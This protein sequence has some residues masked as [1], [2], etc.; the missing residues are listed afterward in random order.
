[1]RLKVRCN[2]RC[3][4]CGDMFGSEMIAYYGTRVPERV[5]PTWFFAALT[6]LDHLRD[7]QQHDYADELRAR[8]G[9]DC[10]NHPHIYEFFNERAYTE[11]RL[12]AEEELD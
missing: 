8:Y 4:H 2:W 3:R 6:L 7:C 10:M 5:K 1:M 9:V 11:S 12:M